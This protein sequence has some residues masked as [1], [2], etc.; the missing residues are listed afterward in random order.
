MIFFSLTPLS[1]LTLKYYLTLF[2]P[3]LA[4]LKH[5]T[6]INII[7]LIQYKN[8]K[9][10]ILLKSHLVGEKHPLNFHCTM[11]TLADFDQ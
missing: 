2:L 5:V 6:S 4:F 8:M 11:K 1:P 3:D 7:V 9:V 10:A